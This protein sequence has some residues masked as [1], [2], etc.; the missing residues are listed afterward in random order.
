M[1]YER[2]KVAATWG[3]CIM[4]VLRAA[5]IDISHGGSLK[6]L[7][8]YICFI[9]E[10]KKWQSTFISFVQAIC[11]QS[12]WYVVVLYWVISLTFPCVARVKLPASMKSTEPLPYY[13]FASPFEKLR[14]PIRHARP[15]CICLSLF[16]PNTWNWKWEWVSKVSVHIS[17]TTKWYK[18]WFLL[19]AQMRCRIMDI[20]LHDTH[21]N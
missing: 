21:Q 3:A 11:K 15:L 16:V 8:G 19:D 20:F 9:R 4:Q 12:S 1:L 7:S 14:M 18:N 6:I 2:E 13:S 17:N 10:K 5:G